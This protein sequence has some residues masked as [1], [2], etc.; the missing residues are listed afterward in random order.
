MDEWLLE[1]LVRPSHTLQLGH[2][3]SLH[4]ER[5][6]ELAGGRRRWSVPL[7]TYHWVD[8]H[9]GGTPQEGE[10]S[11]PRQARCRL[12]IGLRAIR[13]KEPVSR[14]TVTIESHRAASTL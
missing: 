7:N 11:I 14:A 12:V 2:R 8:S 4:A 1:L 9:R 3:R 5:T 13:F 10:G 6:L